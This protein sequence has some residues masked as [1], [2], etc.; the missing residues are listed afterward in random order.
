LAL[1]AG[2]GPARAPHHDRARG[3]PVLRAVYRDARHRL[4]VVLPDAAHRVPR[5][6]CAAPV[7]IDEA[8]GAARQITPGEAAEWMQKMQLAGAVQGTCP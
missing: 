6:D 5:S 8:S 4:L 7:L 1:L 2:C 3:V